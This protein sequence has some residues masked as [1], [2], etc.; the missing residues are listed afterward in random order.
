MIGRTHKSR[1]L[2]KEDSS[3]CEEHIDE[4]L[5]E[6]FHGEMAEHPITN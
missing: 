1:L 5:E 6:T 3:M 2:N 4:S